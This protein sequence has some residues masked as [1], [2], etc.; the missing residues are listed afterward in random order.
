LIF[1]LLHAYFIHFLI[2][3]FLSRQDSLN[4]LFAT[5]LKLAGLDLFAMTA[6]F[7]LQSDQLGTPLQ[8]AEGAHLNRCLKLD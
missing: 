4:Q 8:P 5:H 6:A 2:D 7:D 3:F 1:G